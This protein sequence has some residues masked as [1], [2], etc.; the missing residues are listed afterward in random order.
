MLTCRTWRLSPTSLVPTRN[1]RRCVWFSHGNR[2][3]GHF[4]LRLDCLRSGWNTLRH[5]FDAT[6]KDKDFV[7]E[8]DKARIEI[9][10]M[11]G[12]KLSN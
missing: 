3:A 7:A 8:A 10:P 2:S 4:P 9:N 6:M 12:S 5:A 11:G 1:V